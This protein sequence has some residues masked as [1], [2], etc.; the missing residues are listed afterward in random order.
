MDIKDSIL[1]D[2]LNDEKEH[3]AILDELKGKYE[4]EEKEYIKIKNEIDIEMNNINKC[5]KRENDQNAD[6]I[7]LIGSLF[8]EIVNELGENDK[9]RFNYNYI[10]NSKINKDNVD[11]C[12]KEGERILREQEGKLNSALLTIKL[13][14]EKDG[15]FFSQVMDEAK[16]KNKL[17]KQLLFKTNN[18]IQCLNF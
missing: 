18:I 5:K 4:K 7:Q 1:K 15:R 2:I 14:Q 9:N 10:L 3:N 6:A 13:Y 17:Q 11:I 8:L 12:I 16:K